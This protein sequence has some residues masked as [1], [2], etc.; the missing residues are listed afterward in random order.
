[1]ARLSLGLSTLEHRPLTT[2]P[3]G[4]TP[5]ASAPTWL[6][7]RSVALGALALGAFALSSASL[8]P[9]GAAPAALGA[10]ALRPRPEG[11]SALRPSVLAALVALA[12]PGEAGL[13]ARVAVALLLAALGP[14]AFLVDV[15]DRHPTHDALDHVLLG[16]SAWLVLAA[17]TGAALASP[18]APVH[19]L[20]C[21]LAGL[22]GALAAGLSLALTQRRLRWLGRVYEGLEARWEVVRAEGALVPAEAQPLFL[23]GD[24]DGLL[25]LPPGSAARAYRLAPAPQTPV[26]LPFN[27]GRALELARRRRAWTAAV[28]VTQLALLALLWAPLVP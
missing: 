19:A 28:L 10:L 26:L 13:A 9:F 23:A 11:Q 16:A 18:G 2:P 3:R 21:A 6:P 8:G 24:D 4:E 15:F 1:M 22:A 25:R 14:L 7:L 5:P 20:G 12:W 17:G 27:S